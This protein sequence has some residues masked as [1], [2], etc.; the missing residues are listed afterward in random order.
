MPKVSWQV[1]VLLRDI[2]FL[3]FFTSR[4]PAATT[5][6]DFLDRDNVCGN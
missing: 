2:A 5:L 3:V 6:M 4:L 1:F